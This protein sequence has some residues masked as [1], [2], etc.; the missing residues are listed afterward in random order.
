MGISPGFR[1]FP[2]VATRNFVDREWVAMV[3]RHRMAQESGRA[4]M[5]AL[6]FELIAQQPCGADVMAVGLISL[7]PID[8]NVA[9]TQFELKAWAGFPEIVQAHQGGN[10]CLWHG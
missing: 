7:Q 3:S 6:I 2:S 5:D 1:Y 8:A 4:G 9:P 10:P